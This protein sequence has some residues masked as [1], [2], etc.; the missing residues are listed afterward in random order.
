MNPTNRKLIDAH[1]FQ[2]EG[3]LQEVNRRLLHPLGFALQ[4]VKRD[5]GTTTYAGVWDSRDDLEGIHFA[6]EAALLYAEKVDAELDLRAP[7]RFAALGYVVEPVPGARNLD[8]DRV[9]ADLVRRILPGAHGRHESQ[10]PYYMLHRS[11]LVV[12]GRIDITTEELA[13]LERAGFDVGQ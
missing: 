9:L 7:H 3:Y 10:D 11:S 6:G 2:S 1:D 8:D 5:D 4:V 12:D 13:A